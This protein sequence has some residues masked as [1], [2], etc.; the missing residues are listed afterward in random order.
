M[1][2]CFCLSFRHSHSS[3]DVSCGHSQVPWEASLIIVFAT[4]PMTGM[5][6]LTNSPSELQVKAFRVDLRCSGKSMESKLYSADRG[7]LQR[8]RRIGRQRH[9]CVQ[10][11]A[12]SLG[13]GVTVMTARTRGLASRPVARILKNDRT[14]VTRSAVFLIFHIVVHA[15]GT[16]HMIKEPGDFNVYGYFYVRLYRTGFGFQANLVEESVLC[17]C[18]HYTISVGLERTWDQKRSPGL[19][20]GQL[21]LAITGLM[22]LTVIIILLLLFRFAD[23]VPLTLRSPPALINWYSSWLI[24][25][26][27][28]WTDN[29]H[30]PLVPVRDI[31]LNEYKV[32]KNPVWCGFYIV[33]VVIF[34]THAAEFDMIHPPDVVENTPLTQSSVHLEMEERE[35]TKKMIS[36]KETALWKKWRNTTRK[37]MCGWCWD[38][39]SLHPGGELAIPDFLLGRT[40]QPSST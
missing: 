19:M 1:L 9:A 21:N 13:C 14:G 29:T 37:M 30:V 11:G 26:K 36:Q 23:T 3:M 5:T 15:V 27:F 2:F 33:A 35:M 24:T 4:V 38:F 17:E 25:L 18:A 7:A 12:S 22:L 32:L 16:L 10:G 28:F 40:L 31:F 6:T 8:A 20:S 34:M 39:W